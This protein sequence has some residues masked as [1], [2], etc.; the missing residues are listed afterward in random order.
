[1]YPPPPGFPADPAFWGHPGYFAMTSPIFP[2]QPMP[3]QMGGPI[4]QQQPQQQQQEMPPM[5]ARTQ[6]IMNALSSPVTD[7]PN[8]YVNLSPESE[9]P[10]TQSDEDHQNTLLSKKPLS[11]ETESPFDLANAK[12]PRRSIANYQ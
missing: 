3:N 5:T 2:P 7:S 9:G 6:T 11:H 10:R 8:N 12:R 1:M 4:L